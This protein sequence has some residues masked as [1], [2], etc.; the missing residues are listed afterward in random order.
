MTSLIKSRA[1][2]LAET[3]RAVDLPALTTN[4]TNRGA[5][6]QTTSPARDPTVAT[7]EME[8]R[9]LR[10]ALEDAQTDRKEAIEAAR[11]Q[12]REEAARAYVR[13]DA[14]ALAALQ[15][16]VET[17][18]E[19]LQ[20]RLARVDGL[21]LL[22]CQTALEKIFSGTRDYQDLVARAIHLQIEQLRRETVVR[23]LVSAADFADEGALRKLAD[24]IGAGRAEIRQDPHLP[25]GSCRIDLRLGHIEFSLAQHWDA[26]L[27][28]FRRLVADETAP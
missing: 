11:T 18:V 15:A 12:G 10:R 9:E 2:L 7:L 8:I 21:A 25:A 19:Q 3:I 17:A 13:E 22:L 23:I 28:M 20:D 14:K 4:Q 1:T 24:R 5:Q 26:L 27:A 16:G 6:I